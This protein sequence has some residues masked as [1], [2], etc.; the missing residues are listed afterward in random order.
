[1]LI[2]QTAKLNSPAIFLTMY[3]VYRKTDN[4]YMQIMKP[5]F[6]R[7]IY[8]YM[9][10]LDIRMPARPLELGWWVVVGGWGESVAVWK[11]QP[12]M[13]RRFEWYTQYFYSFFSLPSIV[14]ARLKYCMA[15]TCFRHPV[16][17]GSIIMLHA[18]LTLWWQCVWLCVSNCVSVTERSFI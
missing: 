13:N 6:I 7:S 5:K 17:G 9:V 15:Y 12:N 2:C 18:C 4:N 1:M 11:L 10:L 14:T 8:I 3:T 16:C